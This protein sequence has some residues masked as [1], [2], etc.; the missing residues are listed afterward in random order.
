MPGL[1]GVGRFGGGLR[2]GGRDRSRIRNRPL[3]VTGWESGH[4]KEAQGDPEW[5][6]KDRRI[7][8]SGHR[9]R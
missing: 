2:W 9:F 8:G 7:G 3:V 6:P 1:G 5:N 4:T